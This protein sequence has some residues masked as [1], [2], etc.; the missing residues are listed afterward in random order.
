[1]S[2]GYVLNVAAVPVIMLSVDATPVK[3]EPSP[4]KDTA[5]TMP[6]ECIL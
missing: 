1:M 2:T 6:E 5:V 3:P 4:T